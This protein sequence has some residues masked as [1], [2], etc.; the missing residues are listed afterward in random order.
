MVAPMHAIQM[1]GPAALGTLCFGVFAYLLS[2]SAVGT[3]FAS[4][5]RVLI[6]VLGGAALF[7]AVASMGVGVIGYVMGIRALDEVIQLREVMGEGT[8]EDEALMSR[9]IEEGRAEAMMN[10]WIALVMAGLPLLL[11]VVALV[12]GALIKKSPANS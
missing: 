4:R 12:R 11:S 9:I 1:A 6:L 7:A 10:I 3:A 8:G 5:K 2:I